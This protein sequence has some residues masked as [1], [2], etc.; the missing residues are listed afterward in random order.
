[1]KTVIFVLII[2]SFI[3]TSVLPIDLVLIILICRSY[4]KPN[5]KVNLYLAFGFGLFIAYL[6]LY[7]LGFQSLIYL[8][9]VI[10]TG[11]LSNHRLSGNLYLIIPLTFCLLTLNQLIELIIFK[12]PVQI[13]PK[14]FIESILSL[15]ILYMVKIWEERFIV[16][17]GIKLRV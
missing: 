6:N 11:S 9:L 3:Q 12:Q 17:K 1:M 8:F 5:D 7:K 10:F 15:P 16:Q 2:V 13:F 14:I 4:V